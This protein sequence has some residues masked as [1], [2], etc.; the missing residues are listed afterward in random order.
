MSAVPAAHANHQ[1]T[2]TP[3]HHL[4]MLSQQQ[5]T[6]TMHATMTSVQLSFVAILNSV[7]AA[8]QKRSKLVCSFRPL[9]ARTASDVSSST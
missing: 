8:V 4:T 5:H 6:C 1:A 3:H 2:A 7:S 9:Q